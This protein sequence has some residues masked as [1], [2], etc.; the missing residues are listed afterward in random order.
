VLVQSTVLTTGARTTSA[1]VELDGAVSEGDL[2]VGWF[3]TPEA[4]GRVDVSDNVNGPWTL[5]PASIPPTDRTG[6][7]ALYYLANAKGAPAGVTVT[8]TVSAA[9]PTSVSA[10][11]AEY[12][13]SATA[14]P[15]HQGPSGPRRTPR[16]PRPWGPVSWSSRQW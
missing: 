3:A 5:S 8:V 10:G 12:A 4:S 7:I 1:S 16:R 11:I 13:R 15:S 6:G 9:E 2:L 14:A